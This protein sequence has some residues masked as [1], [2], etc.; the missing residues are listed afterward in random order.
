MFL[1]TSDISVYNSFSPAGLCDVIKQEYHPEIE[2]L[3]N[4]IHHF[5]L[6]NPADVKDLSLSDSELLQLLFFKL[7]D[8]TKHLLLKERLLIFPSI[9]EN[10]QN[11][12][13]H[14]NID[15][16]DMTLL[17]ENTHE[18]IL[19]SIKK[20]RSLLQD[21]RVKENWREEVKQ[22]VYNFECLEAAIIEWI[23]FEHNLLYPKINNMHLHY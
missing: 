21:Y 15:S 14:A 8:E 22:C 7:Q 17:M 12:N 23:N 3:L 13:N 4:K 6:Q 18:N 2:D 11:E 1:R 19:D 20:I 16:K 5:L 10:A 9:Q